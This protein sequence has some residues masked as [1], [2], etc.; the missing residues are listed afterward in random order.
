MISMS[1]RRDYLVMAKSGDRSANMVAV[2]RKPSALSRNIADVR[3][4]SLRWISA[5]GH[6]ATATTQRLKVEFC[7]AAGR[8]Y[9][10]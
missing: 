1:G 5:I 8:K 7:V 4:T 10:A 9:R 6:P 3:L 2:P